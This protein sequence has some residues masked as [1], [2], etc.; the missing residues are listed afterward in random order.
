MKNALA[1]IELPLKLPGQMGIQFWNQHA[2]EY[3]HCLIIYRTVCN[4]MTFL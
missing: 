1:N 3:E 2:G 4:S